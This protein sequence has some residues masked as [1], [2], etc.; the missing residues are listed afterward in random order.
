MGA[1]LCTIFLL[2]MCVACTYVPPQ[3]MPQLSL[4]CLAFPIFLALNI[5]FL[6]LWLLVK[7]RLAL[8]PLVGMLCVG[9]HVWDYCPVH[10]YSHTPDRSD[11]TL[12]VIT[13]N[14]A[15][16][17]GDECE[18][19]A[20]Y[21]E[22]MH[23][24][25]VCFQEISD[26]WVKDEHA[27]KWSA[28]YHTAKNG[29]T[30]I[31]S[32]FPIIDSPSINVEMPTRSNH[33]YA[34]YIDMDGMR[35]ALF[36][37]HLESNHLNPKDKEDYTDALH[38]HTREHLSR[39]GRL[40]AG[41]MMEAARYRGQQTD[42][43]CCWIDAHSEEPIIMCGDCNDTPISYAIQQLSRRLQLAF[44]Q[45]GTGVGISYKQGA[46]PVRID[47]IFHSS[48]WHSVS[49]FVDQSLQ[50]SDHYPLVTYLERQ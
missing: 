12:C 40:L 37:N 16:V 45:G 39:S 27:I 19:L 20:N 8:V 13:F 23:P 49:T 48:H 42:S 9:A 44:T 29:F 7:A 30:R 3:L 18:E 38:D 50:V 32:R 43:L 17:K 5:G 15:Y 22:R 36:N 47:H 24:D 26:T 2:W 1:N 14:A 34:C 46:F 4:P 28:D 31:Y 6:L 41:K 11:S 35:T 10:F 21:L 25:I 33:S